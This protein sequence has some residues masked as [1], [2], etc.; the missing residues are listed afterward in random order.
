MSPYYLYKQKNTLGNLENTGY[1]KP[2][3]EGLYNVFIMDETHSIL[4]TG[5]GGVTIK[6]A[7]RQPH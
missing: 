4:S 2:G 3:F 6:A 5:A 1:A 7:W